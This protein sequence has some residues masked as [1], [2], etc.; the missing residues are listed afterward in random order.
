MLRHG[1]RNVTKNDKTKY[2]YDPS[3]GR[4]GELLSDYG[5]NGTGTVSKEIGK[6][7]DRID[8]LAQRWRNRPWKQRVPTHDAVCRK[9]RCGPSELDDTRHAEYVRQRWHQTKRWCNRH[10][11]CEYRK[12]VHWR[13]NAHYSAVNYLLREWDIVVYSVASF[14]DMCSRNNRVF[15]S[16]TACQAYNWCHY[17][18]NQRLLSKVSMY[19][20]R[21]AVPVEEDG[22]S[23]TC[24]RCSAWKQNLGGNEIFRCPNESCG[25]VMD[26]DVNGA[27]NN[28]LCA[29][30]RAM[31]IKRGQNQP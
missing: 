5:S 28:L 1:D 6:R 2:N 12:L 21:M 20:G 25:V 8:A 11:Q 24:G 27:R 26:R 23:R 14:K 17:G 19:P 31:G 22:T 13:G 18:F 16:R 10:K 30:T 4:H 29:Y 3:N 15:R 7:C 9:L